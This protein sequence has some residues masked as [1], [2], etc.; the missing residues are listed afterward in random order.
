M[1]YKKNKFRLYDMQ[2]FYFLVKFGLVLNYILTRSLRK[3]LQKQNLGKIYAKFMHLSNQV[4]Q[5]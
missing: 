5:G 2:G 4:F 1:K 3:A